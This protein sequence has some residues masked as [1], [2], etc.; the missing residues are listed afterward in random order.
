MMFGGFMYPLS[1][2]QGSF[3]AALGAAG[4]AFHALHRG[5]RPPGRLRR[6]VTMVLFGAILHDAAHHELGNGH[7]PG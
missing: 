4:G 3:S 2:L 5:P 1:S 6:F 7:T